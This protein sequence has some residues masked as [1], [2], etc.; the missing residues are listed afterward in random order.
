MGS[1]G[2]TNRSPG[3]CE[4]HLVQTNLRQSKEGAH[5]L[6]NIVNAF[7]RASKSAN[8]PH[9]AQQRRGVA[10]V[11]AVLVM[12]MVI[13][14]AGLTLDTG[15]GY[16]VGHQ[17]QDAADASSMAAAQKLGDELDVIQEAARM[18][19]AENYASA[20]TILLRM[21]PA[22]DADGD[23]VVGI[24]NRE[25]STFTP[26][27][28][29]ANAV[30]VV[31]RRTEGSLGGPLPL[32]FG[33]IFG[34]NTINVERVAIAMVGGGTGAGLICLNETDDS[35]FR[36]SGT[37]TLSVTSVVDGEGAIQ[38]NSDSTKSLKTDG[39][40]T[41][42]ADAINVYASSV[43]DAP[44]FDGAVNTSQPRIQDPL[45]DLPPPADRTL[46]P[47][48]GESAITGGEHYLEP[49][50][51]PDGISM[52]GGTVNLAPGVYVV[53]GVGLKVTGGNLLGD[54]IMIYVIDSPG[55]PVGDI[56]LTGNGTIDITPTPLDSGPYGGIVLWQSADNTNTANIVGTDNF[57][58]FDGTV[59]IPSATLD[60]EGTSDS[61]GF[62]QLIVD[63]I[64]VHGT[65]T[66]NINY[67]GRFPAP[68]TRVFL[69]K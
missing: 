69:V 45:G 50:F 48:A 55:Q 31:A 57:A 38:V 47:T 49:G 29:N 15:L 13:G 44:D 58:G 34:V 68:G 9:T 32:I 12:L 25:E 41:L 8:G 33:P 24:Y 19:G 56:T 64:W 62:S 43:S 35:T 65:G 18:I 16:M 27:V 36:L 61:F 66:M 63:S 4:M 37:V 5:M 3:G 53:D 22:N 7:H 39:G 14:F 11:W 26:S 10:L 30:K 54:G 51:Y 28:T 67:D 40:P 60:V 52:T 42:L 21:N 46:S 20:E 23:I 6:S 59:Y 2:M 1:V 17:L